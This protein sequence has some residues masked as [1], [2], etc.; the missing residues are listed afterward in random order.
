[1]RYYLLFLPQFAL[2]ALYDWIF[3]MNEYSEFSANRWWA[4]AFL[5][6]TLLAEFVFMCFLR[7]M[8]KMP[9]SK[10]HPMCWF[11]IVM[12]LQFLMVI[13][14]S[15]VD[16]R[17]RWVIILCASIFA[18]ELFSGGILLLVQKRREKRGSSNEKEE[19]KGKKVKEK[20][21]KEEKVK[22][23]EPE[24]PPPPKKIKSSAMLLLMKFLADPGNWDVPE[25]FSEIDA[26]TDMASTST[27][28]TYEELA[29]I[30]SEIKEQTDA[31]KS[32]LKNESLT[33]AKNEVYIIMDLLRKRER[34]I[35]EI[36]KN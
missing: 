8:K 5:H 4:F 19:V 2:V 18:L 28:Y 3:F 10:K 25:G 16:F 35:R 33:R 13:I 32:Y 21:I 17:L 12:G 34:Q 7:H 9:I 6:A 23:E 36:E 11:T 1:M 29:Q 31:L 15:L 22:E 24:L 14:F 27:Q 20:K 30:E 26:L